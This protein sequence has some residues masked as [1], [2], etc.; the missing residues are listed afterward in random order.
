MNPAFCGH[1]AGAEAAVKALEKA[2]R[3]PVFG[4]DME[5]E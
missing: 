2:A 1:A 4:L 5:C 3:V